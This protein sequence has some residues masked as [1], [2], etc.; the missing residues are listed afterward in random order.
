M[1]A[2]PPRGFAGPCPL[3]TTF[4]AQVRGIFGVC[5]WGMSAISLQFTGDKQRDQRLR[6]FERG[7]GLGFRFLLIAES[8]EPTVFLPTAN[9]ERPTT[10]CLRFAIS[11]AA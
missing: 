8:R 5:P 4:A 9:D 6:F 10:A 3:E 11:T 1:S 7:D 2:G